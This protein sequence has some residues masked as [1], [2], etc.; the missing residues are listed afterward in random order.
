MSYSSSV[1]SDMLHI[2]R[3]ELGVKEVFGI[4]LFS[5]GITG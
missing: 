3:S 1:S 4:A 2:R 5:S